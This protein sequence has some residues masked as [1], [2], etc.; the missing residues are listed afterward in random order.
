MKIE[1]E[2]KEMRRESWKAKLLTT[3]IKQNQRKY[4]QLQ[5]TLATI[6]DMPLQC[7]TR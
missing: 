4:F 6:N 1:C 7:S 2:E 3:H 5:Q